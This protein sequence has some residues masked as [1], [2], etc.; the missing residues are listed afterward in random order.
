M[1]APTGSSAAEALKAYR[2]KLEPV[3]RA[4]L[5]RQVEEAAR[6]SPFCR[7]LVGRLREFILR[8]GKRIRPALVY[9]GARCFS[10]G[11]EEALLQASISVEILH[12]YLIILDD[13]MDEDALRRGQ[14]SFHL[15]YSELPFSFPGP[16]PQAYG[17]AM[18]IIAGNLACWM[19]VEA[20]STAPFP[21]DRK[22]RAFGKL[23]EV[24]RQVGY[25]QWLDVLSS[26]RED[27]R[28]EEALQVSRLKT[29]GYSIEA[30]LYL[31]G[32]LGGATDA[33]LQAFAGYATC[34]GQAFQI[35]DDLLD[36]FGQEQRLGKPVGS[37]LRQS[38]KNLP[39]VKALEM[40]TPEDAALLQQVLG[41]PHP[42]P[43]QME[44]AQAAIARSGARDYS[45]ALA[46]SLV[47]QA[48]AALP[49]GLRRQGRDFLIGLAD[50]LVLRDR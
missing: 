6:I 13:L 48:K 15:Q 14:P 30:P 23:G 33:D 43:G 10:D 11:E 16:R 28:E 50:Y 49:E 25:G 3:L 34:L 4:F 32:L 5:D 1:T 20:L 9:Y 44:A 42:T 37:D 29:G 7:D 22:S 27:F 36:L 21:P 12:N 19:A 17:T 8:G 35:Q 2:Q 24:F 26:V 39:I 45:R 41:N 47:E 40:A 46:R 18:A 31:G 38:R